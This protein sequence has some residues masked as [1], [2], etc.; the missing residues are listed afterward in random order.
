M[1][2]LPFKIGFMGV[3]SSSKTTTVNRMARV[4]KDMDIPVA[5]VTEVARDCPFPLN[6]Y[7]SFKSQLWMLQEQIK[8]E[9]SAVDTVSRLERER[10][11]KTVHPRFNGVVLCDRTIW[12]YYA[13]GMALL[14]DKAMTAEEFRVLKNA[15]SSW[16]NV[17][18]YDRLYF[19]EP[20]PLYD[21]GFRDTN[22]EWRNAVYSCFKRMIKENAL[23]VT[24]IQ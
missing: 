9:L 23:K 15:V 4:L 10:Q 3:H 18:S 24:I 11:M 19:C 8:R 13:Y 21:D 22:E 17:L 16:A 2:I 14:E 1:N 20:K 7:G 12:D 6:K 5:V